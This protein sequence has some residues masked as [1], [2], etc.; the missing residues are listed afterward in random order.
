MDHH[1][2]WINNCIGYNNYRTFVLTLVYLVIG[3]WYG[4]AVLS[5]P[6]YEVTKE[7][8]TLHGFRFLYHH[9]TGFLDLPT[10]LSMVRDLMNEGQLEVDVV[11]KILFPFL[12][13]TGM[14]LTSFMCTHLSHVAYGMTTLERMACIDFLKQQA[15]ISPS[16][17]SSFAGSIK[18]LNPFDQGVYS[19]ILQ[20]IGPNVLWAFLPIPIKPESPYFPIKVK[21]E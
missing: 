14:F 15:S 4:V 5:L 10:P 13:F 19:N 12:L 7:Q 2:I 17:T 16:A 20:V 9:K 1:C 6:F 21:D 3:C 8:I 18:V 11:V